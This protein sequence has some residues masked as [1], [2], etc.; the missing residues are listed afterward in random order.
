MDSLILDEEIKRTLFSMDNNKALG[1]DGYGTFLFKEAWKVVEKDF[2][3][4][5][6]HFFDFGH[7]LK[8]LNC[9]ILASVPKV[10]NPSS[11]QDFRLID[12]CN[13]IN[14]CITKILPN[15]IKGILL[16]FINKA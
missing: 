5:I 7:I 8:E 14:K 6:K 15:R 13:T 1:T 2:C 16:K 10:S 3:K 4:T 12:Y 9:T 11:Y